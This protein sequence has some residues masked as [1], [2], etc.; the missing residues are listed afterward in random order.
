M[1]ELLIFL[2]IFITGLLLACWYGRSTKHFRWSEYV[3][4]F[5]LPLLSLIWLIFKYGAVILAIYI[6]SA[7]CGTLLEWLTGWAYH[8][9]IASKLWEY[10]RFP[11][12][13]A[14]Y[15]SW[16]TLPFWG[17]TGIIFFLL[18]EAFGL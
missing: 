12:P 18:V 6:A 13:T 15:T 9:T 2:S 8:K 14:G 1:Y 7:I 5:I 11:V 10:K 4:L 17:F 16:L 3:A